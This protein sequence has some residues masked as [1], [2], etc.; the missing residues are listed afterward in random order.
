[1]GA[2]KSTVGR[3]LARRL[4]R[5]FLDLDAVIET[6]TGQSVSQIFETSGEQSFR[7]IEQRVGIELLDAADACVLATGGGAVAAEAFRL[8]C[9]RPDVLSVYLAVSPDVALER[10]AQADPQQ[11][12]L[13][14]VGDPRAVWSDLLQDRLRW[15]REAARTVDTDHREPG[16]I[17]MEI[18]DELQ[19]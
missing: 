3:L 14:R 1:M 5:P 12:P 19:A 4:G 2:G 18:A 16:S 7:D 15:Y 17:A 13:L 10:L 8:R 6:R 9:R 11:R